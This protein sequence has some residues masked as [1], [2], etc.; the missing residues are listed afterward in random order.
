LYDH[1]KV[2]AARGES[3]S[4]CEWLAGWLAGWAG[5]CEDDNRQ[6]MSSLRRKNRL[7]IIVWNNKAR[8]MALSTMPLSHMSVFYLLI[9]F[10]VITLMCIE[11]F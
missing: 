4:E 1:V 5:Q 6:H 10:I 8:L 2:N 11:Y 3:G 7:F 9:C